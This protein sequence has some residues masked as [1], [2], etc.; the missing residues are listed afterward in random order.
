MNEMSGS[1]L[2]G[3]ELERLRDFLGR[4]GISYDEGVEHSVLLEDDGCIVACGSCRSNVIECLAVDESRRGENL[5]GTVFS[6]LVG[7]LM[8]QGHARWFCFTKPQ[9]RPFIESLGMW[10]VAQTDQAVMLESRRDGLAGYLRRVQKETI[11]Q[12]AEKGMEA[13]GGKCVGAIVANCNPLTLGHMHLIETAADQV[14]LLHVF[15]LAA[16]Q[17][18]MPAA[19]RLALVRQATADMPNVAVH[20]GGDYLVSP[21]TFPTYFHKDEAAGLAANCKLDVE[22]FAHHVAPMLGITKRFVGTEPTCGITRQYNECMQE[23]LPQAGIEL[24]VVPRLEVGAGPAGTR[25]SDQASCAGENLP[26]CDSPAALSPDDATAETTSIPV[27]ASAV[28]ALVKTGNLAAAAPL[29]P[30]CT[31]RYLETHAPGAT[32]DNK[33]R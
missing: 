12:L 21:A 15:V 27:S 23:L 31:L 25:H 29:L 6:H 16:E 26:G 32:S 10:C 20:S 2:R 14:D 30:E 13:A 18:F 28:R 11:G 9:N 19:D 1:P 4:A 7:W 22:L 5:L 17:E 3:G 24:E 33:S 8:G